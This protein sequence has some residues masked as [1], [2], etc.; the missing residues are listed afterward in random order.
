M[1]GQKWFYLCFCLAEFLTLSGCAGNR[2]AD[3]GQFA[4]C[5]N[6]PNCV[7]TKATDE[8]H[9]I[10][11]IPYSETLNSAKNNLLQ[12]VHSLPRTRV[13][14]DQEDYLHVE[15]TSLIFRF[16]DDAEFYLGVEDEMIHFRSASRLGHSDL[17]ANRKRMEAIR[18]QFFSIEPPL[19]PKP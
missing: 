6:T 10:V 12:V 15:F 13:V 8:E 11:P 1:S 5:P 3:L 9:A 17:G 16:V 4:P 14:V 7:S 19:N 2:P 18:S